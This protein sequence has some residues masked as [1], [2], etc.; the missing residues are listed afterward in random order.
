MIPIN[1]DNFYVD[2]HKIDKA[3]KLAKEELDDINEW[4]FSVQHT[5]MEAINFNSKSIWRA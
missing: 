5:I 4:K 2:A 3:I 1:K